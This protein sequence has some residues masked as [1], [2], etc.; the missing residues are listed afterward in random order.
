MDIRN[1]DI[2]VVGTAEY[3]IRAVSWWEGEITLRGF[4]R[5]ASKDAYTKR[6]PAISGGK[7]GAAVTQEAAIK[8][9]PLDP[10]DPEIRERMGLQT[11]HELL[12]TYVPDAGGF[13]YLVLEELKR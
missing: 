3:P 7:V 6:S 2:L 1:G 5:L 9:M 12:Q 10:L 11:P 4:A 8:C 13:F